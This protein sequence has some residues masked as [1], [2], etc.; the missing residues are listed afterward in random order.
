ML[1]SP[2]ILSANFGQLDQDIAML[3]Q[4][5][6]SW[7]HC[8]VMDGN[9]VPNISFGFPI[10]KA[11]KRQAK[12]PLD[13]HLMVREPDRYLQAFAEAGADI[14][15]IHQE[16]CPH[17]HRSLDAIRR[18][19]CKAG[20]ALNPGTPVEGIQEVLP[21]LDVICIMSVNPGFG[22]QKFIPES[23][24]KVRRLRHLLDQ[25][26]VDPLIEVDGGVHTENAAQ[27]AAAGA[28][29]LVAGS[30]VFKSKNP[31]ATIAKL[32]SVSSDSRIS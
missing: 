11:V 6:A 22:G 7:I 18:L 13:V 17:L 15:H 3:N 24:H 16:A 10:L 20:I 31:A 23:I 12:K 8:D 29:V 19:G 1:I 14:I 27:L 21:L 32:A 4:S 2:S 26:G 5:E 9:F 28:N 30:A 25:Q